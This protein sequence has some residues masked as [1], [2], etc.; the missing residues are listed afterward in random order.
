MLEI[1]LKIKGA[2]HK[3]GVGKLAAILYFDEQLSYFLSYTKKSEAEKN[4]I[5]LI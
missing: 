2:G 3:W 1:F 5:M 4:K